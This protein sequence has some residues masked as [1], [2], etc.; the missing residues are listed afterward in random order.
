MK[1]QSRRKIAPAWLGDG[2]L[3]V[4]ARRLL[5]RHE[6]VVQFP[7]LA[8]PPV[9]MDDILDREVWRIIHGMRRK[10]RALRL[11]RMSNVWFWQMA[12]AAADILRKVGVQRH[13]E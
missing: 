6:N 9:E 2:R 7:G 5:K 4:Y 11:R 1:S 10:E 12:S 13:R 8:R 3:P